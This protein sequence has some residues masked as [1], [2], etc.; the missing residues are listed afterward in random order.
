MKSKYVFYLL[1]IIVMHYEVGRLISSGQQQEEGA[2]S[3]YYQQEEAVKPYPDANIYKAISAPGSQAAGR[4]VG[5]KHLRNRHHHN[6]Y[7]LLAK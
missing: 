7:F 3:N 5:K 6:R 1:L 4:D 2:E